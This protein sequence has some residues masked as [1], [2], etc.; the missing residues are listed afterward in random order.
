VRPFGRPPS[1]VTAEC[2]T[3]P[4]AFRSIARGESYRPRYASFQ[5]SAPELEK[6]SQGELDLPGLRRSALDESRCVRSRKTEVR[7]IQNIEPEDHGCWIEH[8]RIG[9]TLKQHLRRTAS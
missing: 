3:S 9:L 4:V 1:K 8:D 7:V 2:L 5:Q 6:H